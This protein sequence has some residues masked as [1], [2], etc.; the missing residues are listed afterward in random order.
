LLESIL[1][2]SFTR[3]R[4]QVVE[5]TD[6]LSDE[7]AAYRPDE[8]SNSIAWLIWHLTRVQDDHVAGLAGVEQAWPSWRD[9]FDLPFD[10]W[11]TGY[12]QTSADVAAVRV[13]SE[14]LAGYHAAVHELTLAYL[15]G[16]TEAELARVVDTRW[17]PPVTAAVRLVS[18]LGD[19]MQ[20]L[21]QAGYVQGLAERHNQ[22]WRDS[23]AADR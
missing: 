21:G 13:S 18:V 1:I 17:D 2:D 15:D 23:V 7:L 11:A 4:E 19:A 8:G 6:G 16:I 10:E 3:I 20:H 14:L 9:R 22:A 5:L 12:G